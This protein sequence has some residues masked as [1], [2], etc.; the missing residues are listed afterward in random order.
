LSK[1]TIH[2]S[3]CLFFLP[4]PIR[5]VH[6]KFSQVTRRSVWNSQAASRVNRTD[7]NR[8]GTWKPVLLVQTRSGFGRFPTGPN[9]RFEFEFKNGKISQNSQ[10]YFKLC[11]I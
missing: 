6:W 1:E 11:R 9:S 4:R 8:S 5:S 2:G 10:K 7:G 3:S